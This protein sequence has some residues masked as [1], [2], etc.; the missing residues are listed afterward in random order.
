MSRLNPIN[1]VVPWLAVWDPVNWISNTNPVTVNPQMSIIS[2]KLLLV[3]FETSKKQWINQYKAI[4][5][6]WLLRFIPMKYVQISMHGMN[7]EKKPIIHPHIS[8]PIMLSA[9][10]LWV[11]S[12]V[13]LVKSPFW[14]T[15]NGFCWQNPS[16]FGLLSP[17]SWGFCGEVAGFNWFPE[18]TCSLV[19]YIYI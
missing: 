2:F 15:K 3:G 14:W 17:E 7:P 4:N 9:H 8:I 13:F 10:F 18:W 5:Q 11:R 16:Q 12:S 19:S 6:K 1:K